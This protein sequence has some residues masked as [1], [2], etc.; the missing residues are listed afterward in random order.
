MDKIIEYPR[1]QLK[2]DSYYCLNGL[3]S[4]RIESQRRSVEGEVLVPFS[5]ESPLGG[6]LE[7]LQPDERLV[8][9][10]H[11]ELPEDF[12]QERLL[13]HFDA[14]DGHSQIEVNHQCVATSDCGYLPIVVDISDMVET[15]FDIHVE[16]QDPTDTESQLRGKQSRHPQGIWYTGQSGIWQSVWLESVPDHYI[17]NLKITPH[18]DEAC[19]DIFVKATY[20][21]EVTLLCDGQ[22]VKGICNQMISIQLSDMHPWTPEDPYLYPLSIS[23]GQDHVSSYFGMRKFSCEKDQEGVLRLFLNNQPYFHTGL[24][25]QG[26]NEEGLLSWPDDQMMIQDIMLAKE[27]GFNM[28]RKHIKIEP[29]RWYYHCDRLGMLVWQDMVSGGSQYKKWVISSPLVTHIHFKDHHYSWFAREDVK[30]RE[31][32]MDQLRQMIEYL[33][34]CPC[35]AMWVP[36][37]EGWGQFDSHQAVQLIQSIDSTR[38]IDHASG[39]HDQKIGDF[40]SLHVY[41]KPYRFKKDRL[42]RCVILSE[43]GGYQLPIFEHMKDQESFGYKAM[44]S[45][46]DLEKALEE[47]Y[48]QQILPAKKQGLS[49]CVYTQLS[50][51][52]TE[53]NGLVTYDR[54]HVKISKEKMRAINALLKE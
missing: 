26:Y 38:T 12:R 43:F 8:M 33:Y 29:L 45:Q 40:Q 21:E 16:I 1:P 35:I 13:L 48:L 17:E 15:S 11:V 18:F 44:A 25:D 42:G 27:M 30:E 49:A 5:I 20:D 31:R 24:L 39:W 3:W 2:R 4:Y 52:E 54:K 23:T 37:N 28:L 9:D 50:D 34:N 46:E 36:F 22:E 14:I 41:F 47:L 7:M 53:V 6:Q 19:V 51:V 10:H 32:F